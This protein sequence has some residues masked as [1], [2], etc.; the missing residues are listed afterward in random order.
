MCFRS[1][2]LE[3]THSHVIFTTV[4][5]TQ[6]SASYKAGPS[7]QKLVVTINQHTT[8]W[9]LKKVHFRIWTLKLTLTW[10][11]LTDSASCFFF[12][13]PWS[14]SGFSWTVQSLEVCL[15]APG[16]L[17][18]DAESASLRWGPR[19]CILWK[20]RRTMIWVILSPCVRNTSSTYT[21]ASGYV[22]EVP[23]PHHP[24]LT[25]LPCLSLVTYPLG[26]SLMPKPGVSL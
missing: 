23:S 2:K 20:G 11:L 26:K 10:P 22:I 24:A 12:L 21:V 17:S 8:T 5:T 19:T 25:S 15:T 16:P 18:R 3:H 4:V 7:H 6:K 1:W 9:D 14:L 13:P